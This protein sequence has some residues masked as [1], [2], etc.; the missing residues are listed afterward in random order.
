MNSRPRLVLASASPR[1]AE[2][3]T[4]IGVRF[5]VRPSDVDETARPNEPAHDY[6][7]RLARA[8]AV[9]AFT[10]GSVVVG[11]DTTVVVDDDI[12][13]KPADADD[14][15]AMLTRLAGR[16][17]EVLTGVAVATD[18]PRGAI[19]VLI[20]GREGPAIADTVVSTTVWMSE[21]S[22]AE[23]SWYVNTG[24]PLD[25]AGAYGIQG[26]GGMFVQYLHGSYQNVVGLPLADLDELLSELGHRLLDFVPPSAGR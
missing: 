16:A 4:S 21:L 11:A 22:P 3:L 10:P 8:K 5:E 1:R 7:A 20:G 12:L 25:K 18:P 14:A 17:H 6:A 15:H 9:R 2:L 19:D 13:G 24:E 23:I 26:I